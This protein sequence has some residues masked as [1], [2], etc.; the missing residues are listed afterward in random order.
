[1]TCV[2]SHKS[3]CLG[4]LPRD[5]VASPPSDWGQ[6]SSSKRED[7]EDEDE[8]LRTEEEASTALEEE[9]EEDTNSDHYEEEDPSSGVDNQHPPGMV[10]TKSKSENRQKVQSAA[11]GSVPS[12]RSSSSGSYRSQPTLSQKL[13]VQ[14]ENFMQCH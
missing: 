11:P 7:G 5:G 6:S 13:L 10:K 3:P 2:K 9:E 4:P 14:N 8:S 12:S 1:M